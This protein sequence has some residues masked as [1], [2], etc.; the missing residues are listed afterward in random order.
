MIALRGQAVSKEHGD[1]AD[2]AE[3]GVFSSFSSNSAAA[4]A[5]IFA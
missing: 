3:K 1:L 4:K 2:I 5:A